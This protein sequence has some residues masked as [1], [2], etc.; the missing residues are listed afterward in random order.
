MTEI[1]DEVDEELRRDRWQKLWKQYRLFIIGAVALIIV[2]VAVSQG[3]KAYSLHRKVISS[4]RFLEATSL[5]R[6]N[7]IPEA[8]S[9]FAVLKENG[10]G[11]YDVLAQFRR[12]ALKMGKGEI[13]EAIVI[14]GNIANDSKQDKLLRELATL[15][16]VILQSET[17]DAGALIEQLAGLAEDDKPWRYSARETIAVLRIRMGDT[18]KAI[19]ALKSLVDDLNAP[20]EMRARAAEILRVLDR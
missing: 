9:E 6:T 19:D 8:L 14:Y 16:L 18:L 4:E 15:Y 7:R 13:S 12:A 17:G 2:G 10:A 5:A 20:R 3:W 1:F 11:G